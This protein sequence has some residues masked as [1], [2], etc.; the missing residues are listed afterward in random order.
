[1]SYLD[2]A[3]FCDLASVKLVMHYFCPLLWA[4]YSL[5]LNPQ[6]VFKLIQW[7]N[8]PR[9]SRKE[10]SF[11]TKH[12]FMLVF[13]LIFAPWIS[14]AILLALVASPETTSGSSSPP[15]GRIG[16]ENFTVMTLAI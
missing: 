5:Y 1:V 15:P 10:Q 9:K 2:G 12:N 6:L 8:T 13:N 14:S 7:E 16:L 11:L 4:L 3:R